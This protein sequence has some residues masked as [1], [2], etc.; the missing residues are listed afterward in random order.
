MAI[1]GDNFVPA[2]SP[3][4]SALETAQYPLRSP[5]TNWN[6]PRPAPGPLAIPPATVPIFLS[7]P[8]QAG[9]APA[10]P[11]GALGG[12]GQGL[13]NCINNHALTLMALGAGI[14]QGGVRHG[15]ASAAT[16]AQAERSLQAQQVNFLQTYQALSDAG[17]PADVARAALTNPSLMRAVAVKYLAPRSPSA[18]P[19]V[20]AAPAGIGASNASPTPASAANRPGPNLQDSATNMVL[21]SARAPALPSNVKAGASYSPFRNMWR[22]QGGNHFDLQGKAVV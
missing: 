17:V 19:G 13:A 14:A 9:A 3:L 21:E 5:A 12:L 15:L 10:Q 6:P 1:F 4:T 8:D 7:P 16:A 2:I 22:D 18:A 20:P 11:A